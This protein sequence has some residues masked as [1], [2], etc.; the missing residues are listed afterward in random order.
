M[1]FLHEGKHQSFL[2]ASTVVFTD[3]SQHNIPKIAC[4][5]YLCNI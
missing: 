1:I 4:L 3:H 2:K 5:S